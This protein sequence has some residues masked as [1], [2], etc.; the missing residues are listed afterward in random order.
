MTDIFDF[1]SESEYQHI[2]TAFTSCSSFYM[3]P[4][5]IQPGNLLIS[6]LSALYCTAQNAN[7]PKTSQCTEHSSFREANP[8][9][10]MSRQRFKG[11]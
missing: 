6:G 10:L 8:L 4:C 3:A 11:C 7:V 2:T 9:S 5:W 1:S